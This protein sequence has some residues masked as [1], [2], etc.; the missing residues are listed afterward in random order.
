MKV[1]LRPSIR[2]GSYALRSRRRLIYHQLGV[3]KWSV[4]CV[5]VSVRYG[6]GLSQMIHREFLRN[7]LD[8]IRCQYDLDSIQ[9][10]LHSHSLTPCSTPMRHKT[11]LRRGRLW[12]LHRHGLQDGPLH[13]QNCVSFQAPDPTRPPHSVQRVYGR[14]V[15]LLGDD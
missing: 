2:I 3:R 15:V 11:G 10:L 6:Y 13:Q 5:Y 9:F 12:G 1:C 4:F 7:S 14:L 8:P